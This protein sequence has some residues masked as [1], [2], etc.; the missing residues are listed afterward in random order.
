MKSFTVAGLG[1]SLRFD[2][3]SSLVVF[4][5]ALPLCLGVAI[6]S[7]APAA[8]GL[9]SGILGGMVVGLLTGCP[10]MVSGPTAGM[11]V[12]VWE[13]T[14]TFGFGG[15]AAAVVVA[16][17]LQCM[18]GAARLGRWFQAISPAVVQ[19]M[20]TSIGLLIV[21]G[22]LYVMLDLKPLGGG[23]DNLLGL[24][25]LMSPWTGALANAKGVPNLVA[26]MV[27]LA[28][29]SMVWLWTRFAPSACRQI[30][31]A[32]LAV[33]LM[34][35]V[36]YVF[37][38]PLLRV[39]VPSSLMATLSF[40]GLPTL[41]RNTHPGIYLAGLS[42][43]LLASTECMLSLGAMAKMA[44][45]TKINHDRELWAQ[46][47]GN[48]ACG[49]I[50]AIP[51]TGVIVRSAA[52]I[53][54][55]AK[56]RLST[57]LHGLLLLIFAA[58]LPAVLNLIPVAVLA[59]VLIYYGLRL[60]NPSAVRSL[61]VGGRSQLVIFACTGVAI[62]ATDLLQGVLL[63]FLLSLVLLL[64]GVTRLHI[65]QRMLAG[66]VELVISGIATFL[67]APRFIQALEKVPV[68]A[69][70]RFDTSQLIF[71]DHACLE[72]LRDWVARHDRGGGQVSLCWQ[73]LESRFLTTVQTKMRMNSSKLSIT[74]EKPNIL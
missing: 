29:L 17:A 12:I 3:L 52:N 34:T 39:E 38:L 60:I 50:G 8:S 69:S 23:M 43:A 10:L 21:L 70:V 20:L 1:K 11:I 46:G 7:G 30:P 32:L 6:A 31:G 72:I 49:L 9:I 67:R 48:I 22:Q 62:L 54:A 14:K 15:L 56:T 55:G 65:Q 73:T 64:L 45:D 63:G 74:I 16:G 4:L 25:H 5:I 42:I 57:I 36:A 58:C 24:L 41:M 26:G 2:V 68:G 40:D 37:D 13:T 51:L 47:I 33:C 66:R 61:A 53:G 44:P 71:I 19:G 27:G 59:G 35:T 28:S 18:A